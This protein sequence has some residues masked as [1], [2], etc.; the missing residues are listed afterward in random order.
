MACEY[1]N[2]S[3][4]VFFHDVTLEVDDIVA[5]CLIFLFSILYLSRGCLS[6]SQ[7]E[8]YDLLF[9]APQVADGLASGRLKQR[10]EETRNI[11][12]KI[13]KT[14]NIDTMRGIILANNN[15]DSDIVIFWG[16]QS[17]KAER[18]ARNLAKQCRN[19]CGM[20]PTLADLGEFD[21][22][23]L[24]NIQADKYVVFIVSTFGEG[25]PPDNAAGLYEYLVALSKEETA[26]KGKTLKTLNY[27]TLGL[28]STKYYHFNRFVVEVDQ[29]LSAAGAQRLGYVGKADEA[30][31]SDDTILTW[32]EAVL[33]ELMDRKGILDVPKSIVEFEPEITLL[34]RHS[35]ASRLS[36]N[37]SPS[38]HGRYQNQ[39]VATQISK[40]KLISKQTAENALETEYLHIEF[41]IAGKTRLSYTTGDHVALW[42]IN[43]EDEVRRLAKLFGWDNNKLNATVDI[44]CKEEDGISTILV[45]TPTTR[46]NLL[47]HN[48]D[49]S[50]PITPET[51]QLLK[52]YAPTNSIKEFLKSF[53]IEREDKALGIKNRFLTIAKLMLLADFE[54]D[55][56]T[57]PD[58]LFDCFIHTIPI[59]QPRYFSISS[60]AVVQ[61]RNIT[62]T[63]SVLTTADV[64]NGIFYGLA[65]NYL[66][67]HIS[68]YEKKPQK[69]LKD[70]LKISR[71]LSSHKPTFCLDSSSKGIFLQVRSSNFRLPTNLQTPI[72]MIGA[73]SGIAPYLGFVKERM[74]AVLAGEQVGKMI[75]IFGIRSKKNDFLYEEE[76]EHVQRKLQVTVMEDLF[77]LYVAESRPESGKKK[78]V[79]DIMSDYGHKLLE[80]LD[81][82]GA[83]Y[84]CGRGKMAASVK[85]SLFHILQH[86]YR[87]NSFKCDEYIADLKASGRF[88]EDVWA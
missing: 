55:S 25:D 10:D 72:I 41:D 63:I 17:G 85:H 76:W 61:P 28:G 5:L 33:A 44:K 11:N 31:P 7:P 45:P 20:K 88:K 65:T 69:S 38:T 87:W 6:P 68:E 56:A 3:Y 14:V 54:R 58:A 35:T 48:L 4:S 42:P 80:I 79:Q 24:E 70:P 37:A 8:G 19:R 27:F 2:P 21:H 52:H 73:G 12:D 15:Q 43:S 30:L 9:V 83:I 47:R 22:H 62:I 50:G 51:I 23:H 86:E 46:L 78:Y 71:K 60:S 40:I 13:K 75:L 32:T 18:V 34:E 82:H 57:W 64:E 67:S 16:S 59:L 53:E 81:K 29:A 84:V 39:P 74:H 66:Y 77:Q 36:I 49:I 26:K 1:R